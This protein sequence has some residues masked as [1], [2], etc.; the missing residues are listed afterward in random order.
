MF[1]ASV[2]MFTPPRAAGHCVSADIILRFSGSILRFEI[3]TNWKHTVFNSLDSEPC[4]CLGCGS[5]SWLTG[6]S[7]F[8]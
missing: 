1:S 5:P 4:F 7:I 2:R 6:F 3:A 8:R